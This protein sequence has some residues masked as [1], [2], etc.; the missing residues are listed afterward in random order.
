MYELKIYRGFICQ[1]NEKWYQI[2]RGTGLSFQNWLEEFEEFWPEHSNVYVIFGLKKYRRVM[3]DGTEDWCKIWR[4]VDLY[5][6][7]WHE[8]FGNFSQAEK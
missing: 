3:F 7:K 2:W 1:D 8:Y 6:P 5:F 4:K